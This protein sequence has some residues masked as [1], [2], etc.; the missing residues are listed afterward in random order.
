M[1]LRSNKENHESKRTCI[2]LSL[3]NEAPKRIPKERITRNVLKLNTE[4]RELRI[5]IE[6]ISSL[7]NGQSKTS[8]IKPS[9]KENTQSSKSSGI[10]NRKSP[11][12]KTKES[13]IATVPQNEATKNETIHSPYRYNDC[14][15]SIAFRCISYF[16]II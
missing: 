6:K 9:K 16:R 15:K 13:Q 5:N 1:N 3:E 12:K 4:E 14:F 2:D 8:S 11:L 7:E 10:I